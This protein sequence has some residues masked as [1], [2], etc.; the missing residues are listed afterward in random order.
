MIHGKAKT[1]KGGK[2]TQAFKPK[3]P[4]E[5]C[6]HYGVDVTKGVAVLYK[7][8]NA[9]FISPRGMSY[10][11]GTIPIAPDWDGGKA[12]CGGGLHFSPHPKM[13]LAF[14]PGAK[15]FAACPVKLT[16]IAVH[17]D[18]DY[19]EKVKASKCCASVWQVDRNGKKG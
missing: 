13:A 12:E 14:N 15:L 19:P 5:W 16:D 3:T 9:D 10:A 2:H 18:G 8:L 11:P 7:A 17:P 4:K 1:L 6:E